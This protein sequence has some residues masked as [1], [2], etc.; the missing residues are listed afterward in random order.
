MTYKI[1]TEQITHDA[2]ND[3]DTKIML[4]LSNKQAK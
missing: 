4:K 1:T 3:E 2:N